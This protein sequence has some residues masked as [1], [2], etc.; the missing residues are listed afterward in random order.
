MASNL[1]ALSNIISDFIPTVLAFQFL[2]PRAR[3]VRST[4]AGDTRQVH[5]LMKVPGEIFWK[6]QI[7][8]WAG[9][10][11]INW[12]PAINIYILYIHYDILYV[13]CK[14]IF[15]NNPIL[16]V[17]WGNEISARRVRLSAFRKSPW[18]TFRCLC[19]EGRCS[20]WFQTGLVAPVILW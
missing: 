2:L 13:Y 8:L 17:P 20:I 6:N 7:W 1:D 19:G 18:S 9:C 3:L 10:V 11:Q 14:Y 15:S 16:G 4:A 12:G 5:E